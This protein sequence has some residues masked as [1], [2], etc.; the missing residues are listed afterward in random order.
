M[1]GSEAE[2][3]Q[4]HLRT[5]KHNDS[6]NDEDIEDFNVEDQVQLSKAQEFCL[7]AHCLLNEHGISQQIE[8]TVYFYKQ[9]AEMGEPKAMLALAQLYE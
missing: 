8:D 3:E 2:D 5:S 9:A 1:E 7:E 6:K 4:E